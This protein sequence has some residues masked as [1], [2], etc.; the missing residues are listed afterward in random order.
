M[1]TFKEFL[2]E[3]KNTLKVDAVE[4]GDHIKPEFEPGRYYNRPGIG[5]VASKYKVAH[6]YTKIT[7]KGGKTQ[8]EKATIFATHPA[9]NEYG[10][11]QGYN[12]TITKS[13]EHNDLIKK[14]FK[15]DGSHIVTPYPN[16]P[17]KA[18]MHSD[19]FVDHV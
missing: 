1:L 13:R 3:E 12:K 7:E 19:K 8:T 5:N 11:Y 16:S 2:L 15:S 14:G 18:L 17:P 9:S 4:Y 10:A 6:H